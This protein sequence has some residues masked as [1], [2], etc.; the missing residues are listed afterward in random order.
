[1]AA[2]TRSGFAMAAIAAALVT[3]CSFGTD[4]PGETVEDFRDAVASGDTE[5]ACEE[6][7]PDAQ[8]LFYPEPVVE[9]GITVGYASGCDD[10]SSLVLDE[11]ATQA[12]SG[13]EVT[14]AS[15]DGDTAEVVT[16]T[17]AGERLVF[18][19]VRI[20]ENWR[21]KAPAELITSLDSNAKTGA[22]K[23]QTAIDSYAT[24]N[25][26]FDG[27]DAAALRDIDPTLADYELSTVTAG[28]NGYT[29]GVT[30]AS[31]TEFAIERD[32]KGTIT[33]TCDAPELGGCAAGGVWTELAPAATP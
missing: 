22:R 7:V 8:I 10:P 23:A 13:T 18:T 33:S 14:S 26:D 19:L 6:I 25:R 1:V 21:L 3:G 30:S 24:R 29:V 16:E 32:A 27:A 17:G 20:D 15:T 9:D 2:L 12:A 4:D 5:A 31:G 11:D 28:G